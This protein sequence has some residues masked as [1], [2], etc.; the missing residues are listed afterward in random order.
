MGMKQKMASGKETSVFSL[1]CFLLLLLS[2]MGSALGVVI[3][4]FENRRHLAELEALKMDARDMQVMWGQY[5]VE[6]STWAA[7]GRVHDIA[8][9]Q[10]EMQTPQAGQTTLVKVR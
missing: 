6:K 4:T 2:V 7:Y 3:T 5:L 9:Q 8:V 10:L 1:F